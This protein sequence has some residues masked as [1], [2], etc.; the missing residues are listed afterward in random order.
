MKN[1]KEK[2]LEIDEDLLI[3]I[4]KFMRY[5]Y[6]IFRYYLCYL[7]LVYCL[8]T[9]SVF[10]IILLITL[11]F[12]LLFNKQL[13]YEI[14]ANI[15]FSI[16]MIKFIVKFDYLFNKMSSNVNFF[17]GLFFNQRIITGEKEI[18]LENQMMIVHLMVVAFLFMVN[19]LLS[20][21]K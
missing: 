13:M 16:T 9:T 2:I 17:F 10:N 5:I 11:F 19:R 3:V 6:I 7:I 15:C 1:Q 8:E 20:E 14:F 18:I 12:S 21:K 4:R